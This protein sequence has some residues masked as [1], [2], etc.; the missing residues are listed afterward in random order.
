MKKT[1]S[2][3]SGLLF[4]SFF[5][6]FITASFAQQEKKFLL[7]DDFEDEITSGPQG[8]VDAGSGNGSA[9]AVSADKTN[10]K[11]GEQSLKIEYDA[12]AG[13]YMW[14]ARGY[15]LDVAGAAGWSKKPEEIEWSRYAAFSFNMLGAGQG[16]K[17]AFD[18]KDAGGEIFRFMVTDDVKEWK[19]VVCPFDQFFARG[20][21]QP[22]TAT[23]NG[24]LDFPI[25]SFQFEPIAVAK[26]ALCIDEVRLEALN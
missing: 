22:P 18:V 3:L 7:L 17:I 20:D 1:L 14:V 25:R 11:S 5:I 8:A 10:K 21:W 26:G 23:T 12:M 2:H 19:Q 24:T 9:V 15:G 4:V 6:F 13:G 16:A